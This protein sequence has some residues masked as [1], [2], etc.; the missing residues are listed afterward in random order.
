MDTA[1]INHFRSIF[2]WL[3]ETHRPFLE[4]L[5]ERQ[6]SIFD[7]LVGTFP[8]A[9]DRALESRLP[10]EINPVCNLSADRHCIYLSPKPHSD[11]S[12]PFLPFVS[13]KCDFAE[14]PIMV[15]IY[16][17]MAMRSG[18]GSGHN[19]MRILGFRYEA[20][21]GTGDGLHDLFHMQMIRSLGA[22]SA[23]LNLPQADLE[24]IPTAQP[25][26]PLDA[27]CPVTLV[28]SMLVSLYGMRYLEQ[29]RLSG[30]IPKEY[31]ERMHCWRDRPRFWRARANGVDYY[32]RTRVEDR[33]RI[34]LLVRTKLEVDAVAMDECAA[35]Q[36]GDAP[37]ARKIKLP[38]SE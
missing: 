11:I 38:E 21:E 33:D 6:G 36:Y 29:V 28:L 8:Q 13:L 34:K 24:W 7:D 35:S 20:P 9:T 10:S 30:I 15:R 26:V 1:I 2:I 27:C 32:L 12:L 17:A 37:D 3:E 23:S 25:S 31:F 5:T 4:R 22:G 19:T 16:L 14:P 18:D